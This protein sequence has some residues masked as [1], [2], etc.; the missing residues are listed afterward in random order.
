M[1]RSCSPTQ[2]RPIG[3]VQRALGLG[4]NG[5]LS[6]PIVA[7]RQRGTTHEAQTL[8]ADRPVCVTTSIPGVGRHNRLSSCSSMIDCRP[9]KAVRIGRITL[10]KPNYSLPPCPSQSGRPGRNIHDVLSP[11]ASRK[12]LS[13]EGGGPTHDSGS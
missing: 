5:R 13:Q 7:V 6:S 2:H 9:H 12:A 8:S 11:I 10:Q 3:V 1:C 4:P